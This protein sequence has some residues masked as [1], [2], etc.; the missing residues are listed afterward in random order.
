LNFNNDT[1]YIYPNG[2]CTDEA[3]KVLVKENCTQDVLVQ[4]LKDQ[5][6]ITYVYEGIGT[7]LI[8]PDGSST[9]A[10]GTDFLPDGGKQAID[11]YFEFDVVSVNDKKYKCFKNGRCTEWDGTPINSEGGYPGLLI[12]LLNHSDIEN[13]IT[14]CAVGNDDN[15][16]DPV[17]II[18]YD[19]ED[20]TLK[21]KVKTILTTTNEVEPDII[22]QDLSSPNL[23][24]FAVHYTNF[25][26]DEVTYKDVDA[27]LDAFTDKTDE[28]TVE[29]VYFNSTFEDEK[30]VTM[31]V[32]GN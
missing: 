20:K 28:D 4:Y 18:A 17:D 16:K 30:E 25:T 3:G 9:W 12:H 19:G 15:S 22:N 32:Q 2:V 26:I 7:F 10:N 1:F 29:V 14:T 31:I 27:N 24:H 21:D 5:M 8:Y 23:L 13:I 11:D 6:P